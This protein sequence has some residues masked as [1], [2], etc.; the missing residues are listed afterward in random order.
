MLK[1]D[2]FVTYLWLVAFVA[3]VGT[4][5]AQQATTTPAA[6]QEIRA[7]A[8]AFVESFKKRDAAAIAAHWTPD[9]TYV[10]EEG[11][12]FEGRQAIQAE[13]EALF[14]NS[15]DELEMKLEIDS[16]RLINPQTA[17]EEGRTALV[18]QPP[19]ENRV[20]S[21]YTAVH[22]K[23][24][25]GRWLMSDVRD[26]LVELPPDMGQLE[27]LKWLVG[28]WVAGSKEAQVQWKCRWIENRH[29]L[30]RSHS[31]TESGKVTST[32]FEIIGVDPSTSWITSWSFPS[33]G[34]HAMGI[35]APHDKGW[36]VESSG[37]M[38]DGTETSA[39]H[40]LSRKDDNTLI[41]SSSNRALGDELLPD[42]PDVTLKRT[43]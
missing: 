26:T 4:V 24:P 31:V 33:T 41:W 42:T 18:P 6:D 10:N 15:S 21:R 12:R 27:D 8:A 16:I 14:K 32:G 23:Q 38:K 1:F 37:V 5:K 20:M 2:S 40:V 28:T 11:Q 34:A 3:G 39:T 25:D 29:F 43:E 13:Y 7:A 22:V 17:M 9:G 36:L 19:G 35:W 30:A